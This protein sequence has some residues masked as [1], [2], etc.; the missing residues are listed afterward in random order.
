MRAD[1][2]P[3]MS[4]T[5]QVARKMAAQLL[6]LPVGE[7]IP[8]SRDL[9]EGMG[10]GNGTIQA[11]LELLEQMNAIATTSRGRLGT[12]L[13]SADPALLWEIA[14]MRA[15]ALA[16]PLPYSR[17]YEGLATGLRQAF[18]KL[19]IPLSLSF[20]R[21]SVE[22]FRALVDGQLD[23][24]VASGLALETLSNPG[25]VRMLD[26][27]PQTYVANHAVVLAPGK[28]LT[29]HGLQVGVDRASLD[30]VSLLADTFAGRDDIEY[31]DVAFNQ[32]DHGFASG[33]VDATI[34]NT[35]E[36][37]QQVSTPVTVEPLVDGHDQNTRAVL[38]VRADCQRTPPALFG[39]LDADLIRRVQ[40]EVLGGGQIPRY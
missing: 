23:I 21:G 32:L 37:E 40:N 19:G 10:V 36:I 1:L 29:D 33:E 24:A 3:L 16:M 30:Q 13:D 17:R 12:F 14:G 7:R 11:G 22:R 20:M 26:L 25:V 18:D 27:G 35:D 38:A 39:R 2:D 8:R 4:R 31:V 6:A 5:G 15:V 9:S 28:A 34:W